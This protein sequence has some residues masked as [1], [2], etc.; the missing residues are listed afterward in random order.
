MAAVGATAARIGGAGL[1]IVRDRVVRFNTRGPDALIDGKARGNQPKLDDGQRQALVAIVKTGP[2][3]ALHAVVRWRMGELAQWLYAEFAVLL[4]ETTAGRELKKPGHVKLAGRP[5]HHAQDPEALEAFEKG[6]C[7]RTGKRSRRPPARRCDGNLVP[8]RGA[9]RSEK[10]DHAPV[11][12]ARDAPSAPHDQRTISTYI[13]GAICPAPGKGAGLVLPFYNT[14]A[15][16]L[17]LAEIARTVAPGAHAVLLMDQ[18]GRASA[19]SGD[20]S[21]PVRW[22]LSAGPAPGRARQSLAGTPARAQAADGRC[23]RAGQ[24]D[25]A[26]HL[27]DAVARRRLSR[28]GDRKRCLIRQH[29]LKRATKL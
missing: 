10:Q 4:D 1:P 18:A 17:Q 11:G 29:G 20:C 8:G 25:G 12:E 15:M 26:W 13:L 16:N 7:N 22:P 28:P 9:R 3:P 5:R 2:I 23:L 19:T 24:Q 27:G 14:A 6:L 21:S